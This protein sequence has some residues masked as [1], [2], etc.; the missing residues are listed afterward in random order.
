MRNPVFLDP[1]HRRGRKLR[2]LGVLTGMLCLAWLSSFALGVYYVDILPENEKLDLIRGGAFVNDGVAEPGPAPVAATCTGAPVA[3]TKLLPD[4]AHIPSFAYLRV[5][6]DWAFP[7]LSRACGGLNGV[8]AEWLTIDITSQT[9]DWLAESGTDAYLRDLK[10][11]TP[12]VN[13]ELVALLPLPAPEAVDAASLDHGEVRA[14]IVAALISKVAGG[15]YAGV[16][17]Y[18]QQVDP[19]HLA[20]LRALLGA[21]DAALPPGVTS[22]LVTEADRGLWRDADLVGAV[23]SVLVQAFRTPETGRPPSP[24]ASQDWFETL[25]ADVVAAVG[26]EKLRFALGSF[27]FLWAEG[28]PEPTRLPFAEAMRRIAQHTSFI[29]VEE[30]SLNTRATYTTDDGDETEIWI[31]DAVS[32]HNQL[33]TLVQRPVAGV[34][35]WQVGYEDPA[36]WSLFRHGLEAP[37]AGAL[38]TVSFPDYVS[39]VGDGP[40]RKIILSSVTGQR[41][42]FTD[43]A[44]GLING[45]IYDRVPRPA[46]VERYGG[47]DEKVVALTFDDGPDPAYT[48]AILDALKA[49]NVSATFFVIG[50]NMVK[51]PD[52]VRRMVSDGHEVGSH[53][54]FHPEGEDM[55][56]RRS[57]IELNALQ[58]LLASV[59]GRTTYLIR[60]PYGRSEGPLTEGEAAQQRLFEN[61]GYMVAG[62]DIVPRDWEGMT[63][64][65]IV[66]FVMTQKKMGA[67]EVIVMHDAG[68]DRA[69]TVAAVPMLIDRLM[70][71]GYRFVLLSDFLGLSR[72]EVMPLVTDKFRL[73]D[74]AS[75]AT[76]AAFGHLLVWVFWAAVCYGV[77]RSLFVLFL[78]LLRRQHPVSLPEPPPRVTVTIPAYNEELVIVDG[79]AAA[80]ASDYPDLCVIVIDDGSTDGTA[81]AVEQAFGNDPR[82]R[83]IRQENG[84]KCQALNA[85]YT[86][87]E[88]EVVVAVDADTL[89]HPEAVSKLLG[90]FAD[91]QIGAVAGNVKVGNRR[92]LLAR[93]QALEY[94]AAQNIDRRAAERLNAMLVVP[95]AIGAWRAEAVRGVGLYSSDTITEDADLTVAIQRAGYRVVFEPCAFSI[96]DAPESL[97]AFMK[98]R[99]R[100]SFGMMQT[101][102]K[103]RRAA[104]TARGIGFFSIPDLWLTGIMLGLLAPMADAVFLGVL[105]NL[106]L[107]FVQGV[108]LERSGASLAIIAGW[109]A[110]PVLD[111]VVLLVAFGFERRE[112]F[113]LVLLVPFQRLIY[114]PLL[115]ITI[116]RAVGH[117]LVGRIAGW[118]KLIRR[119]R[120]GKPAA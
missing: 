46:T 36:A 7:T 19:Q 118:G 67:G 5:W 61:A 108:P 86:K 104:K 111:L 20:G 66:D 39:Y 3:A 6:P 49:K 4:I 72:D 87:I 70:A 58:R 110:L 53:T 29:T 96:T 44:T 83:L 94:I 22:C 84:G 51:Y 105:I 11:V 27:A 64:N 115:Y 33:V 52:I 89:L 90:H 35:L 88:T 47:V 98:Q 77:A 101:A 23:D 79:I 24:I 68:G 30:G 65:G 50:S 109:L 91:P 2:I 95:G 32:L 73:L 31:L 97:A 57:Q 75:F 1:S 76:A 9:V 63:A 16:C 28:D 25:L 12:A 112:N 8:L 48:T 114:R 43:P 107:D 71:E 78:A 59:T 13:L 102:W 82:V 10:R 15:P 34:V 37:R 113:W 69:A 14:R 17:I 81:A 120:I 119:G 26:P 60:T 92:G 93:L 62:A 99:L 55:G 116:Y 18:P 106:A 42:F 40:F 45:E 41:R 80:L 56:P 103:H 100:W 21:L 74:R 54:F 85:A 38:E 117:A